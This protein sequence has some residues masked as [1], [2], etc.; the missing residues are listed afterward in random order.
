MPRIERLIANSRLEVQEI[1]AMTM[2]NRSP[3][4]RGSHLIQN[5]GL[6]FL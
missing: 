3:G 4:M 6:L 1:A 2:H 5:K